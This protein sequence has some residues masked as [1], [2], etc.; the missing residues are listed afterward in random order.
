MDSETRGTARYTNSNKRFFTT[1]TVRFVG[2]GIKRAVIPYVQRH[3]FEG[4]LFSDVDS[5]ATV[6]LPGI[7]DACLDSL[8]RI[9]I[10]FDTPEDIN[11]DQATA[12]SKRIESLVP[13]YRKR[14][15][16]PLVAEATGLERIRGECPGFDG[17]LRRL[18]A[19]A[20]NP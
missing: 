12:P 10:R 19:L 14:L 17:W 1:W 18:E 6:G 15:H 11:D 2:V 9:R 7:D 16:G 5:F 20:E 8:R 13:R 3:E 4:L